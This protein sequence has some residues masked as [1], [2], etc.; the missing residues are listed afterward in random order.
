MT[1]SSPSPCVSIILPVYNS[2]KLLP[3]ALESAFAQTFQDFEIIAVNDGS[4]DDTAQVLKQYEPRI[5]IMHQA[6]AGAS[7]ARNAAIRVAQGEFIA[8]LDADDIWE[9]QKLALQVEA[10][11]ADA[12]LGVCYTECLYF[13]EEKSWLA[14]FGRH[15]QMSGMIFDAILADHFISMSSVLVRKR[16]LD[17]VGLF[18]ES[19]IGSEDYNVYLRLAKK[20][21]YH[22]VNQPLVRLRCHDGNLSGNLP[23]MCRDEI[24]NLDKIAA[25]FPDMAIPKRRLSAQLLYRFGQYHFDAH[26]FKLARECFARSIRFGP[27]R[28]K[29]YIYLVASSLPLGL[30]QT[31][32]NVVRAVRGVGRP[33]PAS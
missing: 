23:Q 27:L 19:L 25:M 8:F 17:E 2:A 16:C 1:S 7:S 32:R 13:D 30:L 6:N 15:P 4:T 28:L 12:K 18:D 31:L 33:H 14:N 26:D 21:P 22:F 10:M 24:A 3:A 9:P 29:S 20:Y 5:R 11:R